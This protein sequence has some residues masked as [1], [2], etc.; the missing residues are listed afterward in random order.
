MEFFFACFVEQWLTGSVSEMLDL[1]KSK[2]IIFCCFFLI[3]CFIR[4]RK[5]LSYLFFCRKN[6]FSPSKQGL[7]SKNCKMGIAPVWWENIFH[8]FFF[9]FL[10][11]C[12][13]VLFFI[14]FFLRSNIFFFLFL[15]TPQF[16]K[17]QIFPCSKFFFGKF[18]CLTIF[19][20]FSTFV[21]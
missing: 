6:F 17:A 2:K 7:N 18:S 14:T 19:L 9:F 10:G 5:K 20:F 4:S 21:M 15:H 13:P 12:Y 1:I 8:N 3:H 16:Y 11:K